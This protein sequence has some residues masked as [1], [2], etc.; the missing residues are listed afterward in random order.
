MHRQQDMLK[1]SLLF[2]KNTN[3]LVDNSRILRIRNAKFSRYCF[4]M[5]R[6]IWKACIC[7]EFSEK[8]RMRTYLA[9]KTKINWKKNMRKVVNI[10]WTELPPVSY[11]WILRKIGH[12]VAQRLDVQIEGQLLLY[13]NY[14]YHIPSVKRYPEQGITKWVTAKNDRLRK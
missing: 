2:K 12:T 4:Y 14:F 10:Q 8:L 13:F 1:S 5:N 9:G 11:L 3:S 6:N 7:L